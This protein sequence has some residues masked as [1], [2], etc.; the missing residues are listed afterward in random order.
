MTVNE[1]SLT[2]SQVTQHLSGYADLTFTFH[3]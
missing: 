3:I 1:R 2:L